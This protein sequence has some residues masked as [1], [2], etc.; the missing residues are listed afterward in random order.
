MN[1]DLAAIYNRTTLFLWKELLT[2]SDRYLHLLSLKERYESWKR[3]RKEARPHLDSFLLLPKD[4]AVVVSS[5]AVEVEDAITLATQVAAAFLTQDHGQ[6]LPIIMVLTGWLDGCRGS[7]EGMVDVIVKLLEVHDSFWI[8]YFC[9]NDEC[10]LCLVS[11][12]CSV[13]FKCFVFVCMVFIVYI[14]AFCVE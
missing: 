12:E 2:I 13:I 6:R 9:V 3:E 7:Q 11:S 14:C 5:A 10:L 4:S 8:C 1:Q